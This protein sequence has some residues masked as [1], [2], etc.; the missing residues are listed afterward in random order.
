V[1]TLNTNDPNAMAA[2]A[3]C[4]RLAP[5][6]HR[7]GQLS[8]AEEDHALK[9]AECLRK[10]GIKAKDPAPGTAEVTLDEGATYTK[11][12]LVAAYTACSKEM[13]APSSK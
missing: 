4:A 12:Q 1:V 2:Q 9:L 13:P 8:A 10:R 5:N 3:A 7:Q 11:E 6:P